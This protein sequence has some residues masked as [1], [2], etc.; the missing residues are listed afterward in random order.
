MQVRFSVTSNFTPITLLS[1]CG[2]VLRKPVLQV[3]YLPQ[4]LIGEGVGGMGEYA[5]S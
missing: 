5:V 3:T 1:K 2:S 4:G